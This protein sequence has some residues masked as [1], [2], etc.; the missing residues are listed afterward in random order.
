MDKYKKRVR[1]KFNK[2][3][4]IEWLK[5]WKYVIR[6]KFGNK[7]NDRGI[8]RGALMTKIIHIEYNICPNP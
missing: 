2:G 4:I 5:F 8:P 6:D 3:K 7:L 1:Y